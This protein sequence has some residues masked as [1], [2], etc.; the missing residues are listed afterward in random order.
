MRADYTYWF[1]GQ[2]KVLR[3]CVQDVA[4]TMSFHDVKIADTLRQIEILCDQVETEIDRKA[5]KLAR[6]E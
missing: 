4:D 5:G 3:C 6:S 1:K 2:L